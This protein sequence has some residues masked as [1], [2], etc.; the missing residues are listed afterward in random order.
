MSRRRW[1]SFANT[2]AKF[3]KQVPL[4]LAALMWLHT[5]SAAELRPTADDYNELFKQP[6]TTAALTDLMHQLQIAQASRG[7][8]QQTRWLTVLKKPLQSQGQFLFSPKLGFYWQQLQPF[9]TTLILQGQSL[10]QVDSQGNI[11]QQSTSAAPSQLGSLLQQLMR[12][13]LSADIDFLQQHFTLYLQPAAAA[14]PW[15]LGLI[16]SD[17]EL[18]KLLPRIVLLGNHEVQRIVM[19][20]RQQD[21]SEIKLLNVQQGALTAAEQARFN[22]AGAK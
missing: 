22:A 12:A 21:V 15:R 20:G 17:A 9:A 3:A 11:S 7:Q 8:F 10:T 13:L 1:R 19:L 2:I 14:E 4:M 18:S 5:A 16:A 6:A